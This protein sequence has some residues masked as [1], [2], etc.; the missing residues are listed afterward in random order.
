MVFSSAVTTLITPLGIPARWASS[1]TA[2]TVKGV[3]AGDL[4]TTVQ[5]AA[6][7]APAF[8]GGVLVG[9]DF[10]LCCELTAIHAYLVTI[11]AGKFHLYTNPVRV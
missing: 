6:R 5:P 9:C 11:A 8:L 4:T 7:A 3:S 10:M 2:L 1:T